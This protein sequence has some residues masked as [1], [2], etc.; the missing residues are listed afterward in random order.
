MDANSKSQI[1]ANAGSGAVLNLTQQKERDDLK[2]LGLVIFCLVLNIVCSLTTKLTGIP[3]Y[4]DC[5]GTIVAAIIGGFMPSVLVGFLTNVL[6]TFLYKWF[7]G[8]D[9][10]N[11]YYCI[12]SVLIALV[13]TIFAQKNFFKKIHIKM[14][15][16]LICFV[17]LGGGLGSVI[18]WGLYGNTMGEELASSLAG[19]IYSNGV[20][21]AFLAQLYAGLIMD[22][23]DKL[24]S[25][26]LAFAIYKAYP[27]KFKPTKDRIDVAAL[28]KKGISLSGKIIIAVTLI[29]GVVAAAVTGVSLNQFRL[30]M[31]E[32]EGKYAIDTAKFAATLVDGNMIDEY[33]ERRDSAEGYYRINRYFNLILNSSDRI[34]Y[35]YVYQIKE[36]G[37][38]V[39]FDVSTPD[40]PA[41]ETGTVIP[42]DDSFNDHIDDLL[43]G[44]EIDPI[45]TDDSYGWL[46]SAYVPIHDDHG[47]CTAYACVDVSM[48]NVAELERSF[49]FKMTTI[50]MGFFIAIL[51]LSV[52]FAKRFIV[53]PVNSLAKLA[54]EFAYTNDEARKETLDSIRFLEIKTGD[55][56]EHL[57]DAMAKTTRD[58]VDFI[59]ES[60][61]KQAA[62]STFQ[63]G[64]INVMADLVESRDKSTGTHIKNTSAYVEIICEELIKDGLYPEIVNEEYKNNVV[65]SAP[66]HD[67]GKIKISDAILN[68][69]GRF[70]DEEYAIMKTHAEEGAKIISTVKKTVESDA[71]KEDY[72]GE[73]ENMAHYH[74]EKWNGEGYPCGLK[75]EEI[76]LSARIM[77]VADVFD[78][79][80]A[81]R[82]YK[83]GM[84]FE[85]AISIIKESSGQHFDPVI[86]QAF[87]NAED[88]I[89][90]VTEQLH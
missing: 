10:S 24:I 50:L 58:T 27:K 4:F 89:R 25:T 52:Y 8:E 90:A 68:K 35:L 16:P 21:S 7:F 18:T 86:V 76:P 46:L 74:H 59:N 6:S 71:L 55:E 63:S 41:S 39:V 29:F 11:L 23:P 17:I 44:R 31:V 14:V 15:I 81:E 26:A 38:H 80:V 64:M 53:R 19:R 78:A 20:N 69:P 83:P 37:C 32:S 40:T 43:A 67:I 75:G 9:T 42:F 36:D 56:I 28:A 34:K 2:I 49:T 45:I 82:V 13:A 62:I 33:I 70:T 22:V 77:A 5:I 51:T 12:I 1:N 54:G 47:K 87:L 85:S 60:Q 66:M 3:F 72:L 73:A 48:P 65:A 84:S 79:L 61:K 57:Y 88:K 30:T